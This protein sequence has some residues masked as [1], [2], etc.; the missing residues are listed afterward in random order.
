MFGGDCT[1][2][3]SLHAS[4]TTGRKLRAVFATRCMSVA[5]LTLLQHFCYL[6]TLSVHNH[7]ICRSGNVNCSSAFLKCDF[8]LEILGRLY[9]SVL[10]RPFDSYKNVIGVC[11]CVEINL[12]YLLRCSD[13][14]TR[15]LLP[16]KL[17]LKLL[18]FINDS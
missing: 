8:L 13:I 6:Q 7:S 11:C 10:I 3:L 15:Y 1:Y 5:K 18:F 12:T 14:F 2:L 16:L 4:Y 17:S 9:S